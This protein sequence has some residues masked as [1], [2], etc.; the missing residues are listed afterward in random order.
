MLRL[1]LLVVL[2][3]TALAE[4]GSSHA[5]NV[6]VLVASGQRDSDGYALHGFGGLTG[7]PRSITFQASTDAIVQMGRDGARVLVR[8]GDPLPA[9]LT[10]TFN[11][12]FQDTEHLSDVAFQ[13]LFYLTPIIYRLKDLNGISFGWL[14][15]GRQ[16]D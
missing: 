2:S 7:G 5:A 9:P 3:V 6:D 12:F 15:D 11:V 10:G 4:S 8:S 16:D 1:A 14:L 13:I